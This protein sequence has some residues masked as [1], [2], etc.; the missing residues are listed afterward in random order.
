MEDLLIASGSQ[1][2]R[3]LLC[4]LLKDQGAGRIACVGSGSQARRLVL[5][6]AWD[7]ALI[8]LPCR[9]STAASWPWRSRRPPTRGSS[10]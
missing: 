1:K 2:A 8:A 9:T 7:L 5:E 10:C 6:R 3:Q 4:G